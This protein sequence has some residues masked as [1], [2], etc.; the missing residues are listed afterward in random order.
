VKTKF[1]VGQIVRHCMY[2]QLTGRIVRID[3]Q[4]WPYTVKWDNDDKAH[5]LLGLYRSYP[6]PIDLE[7][8][9]RYQSQDKHV[10]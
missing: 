3:K 9:D 4:P 7:K 10:S 6:N 5:K 8:H 2:P 1:N